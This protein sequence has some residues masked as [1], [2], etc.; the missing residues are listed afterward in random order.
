MQTMSKPQ[1]FC[2]REFG[3]DEVALI[4]EIVTTCRGISRRELSHTVCELLEWKRPGGGLK[5]RECL[6]LLELLEAKGLLK[7]PGKKHTGY[8]GPQ[9]SIAPDPG[10]APY[11]ALAGSVEDF[12]PLDVQ[13]VQTRE[14]RDLFRDLLSRYHYLGY[15]MPFGARL[16]YLVSVS[17]PRPEVLGCIQFSSPAWRM[18]AR[19][20]WI[21][22]D[23]ARREA[24]LQQVVNNSRFLVLARIRN[25]ASAILACSLRRLSADWQQQ[26]GIEP[27]LV[28]TLVD[29]QRFHGGCYRAA[30]WIELGE[31]SGRGRMDRANQRHGA[32]V[33]TILVYPLVKNAVRLLRDGSAGPKPGAGQERRPVG[34]PGGHSSWKGKWS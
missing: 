3:A 29:R 19:D 13:R 33:K 14:Q 32:A 18:K 11:S 21:G 1:R 31:T 16:Q 28:E 24:A 30:N 8:N 15:A 4:R 6:D 27:L 22:W 5:A 17:R 10:Q 26:Y 2:G 9:K 20:Q 23:D 7:L 25:L 34:S 12:A